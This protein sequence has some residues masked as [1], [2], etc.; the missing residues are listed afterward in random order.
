MDIVARTLEELKFEIT[1]RQDLDKKYL[2]SKGNANGFEQLIKDE[3]IEEFNSKSNTLFPNDSVR[4]EPRFGHHFPDIDLHVNN[5]LYGI[6]LKSRNN[7]SWNTLGGSVIESISKD[8]YKEIYLVFASFNKKAGETA[9]Q[10]R[11]APYWEVADAIKVTHSPRFDINLDAKSHVFSSNNDYKKLREMNDKDTI[12]FIQNVLAKST[13][14]PTWYSNL[15]EAVP[16]TFFSQLDTNQ[17]DAL[18]AEL[19]MLFPLDL[20]HTYNGKPRAKYERVQ[21]YL[22]SQHYVLST[23]DVF[24]AGGQAEIN[25]VKFPKIVQKYQEHRK[26]IFKL[27]ES[28]NTDFL[29]LIYEK[30]NWPKAEGK[31]IPKEDFFK[32]INKCGEKYLSDRIKQT[33]ATSLSDLIF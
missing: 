23:R 4:L 26:Q 19:L 27:L 3:I 10:V 31:S 25:G 15:N 8:D 2:E 6:E 29:D 30:W 28:N 20:L 18:R 17:K 33:R 5:D 9:Y 12:R 7:G 1:S 22:M 13:T 32:V 16:P 21:E 14:K 11:Y 24:S